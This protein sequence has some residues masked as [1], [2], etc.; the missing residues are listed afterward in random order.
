MGE[1]HQHHL[2]VYLT[3]ILPQ[4]GLDAETYAPYIT[5]ILPDPEHDNDRPQNLDDDEELEEEL[6]GI[7]QLL[8]AS[9][10][11]HCD[12]TQTWVDLKAAIKCKDAAYR[13]DLRLAR[14]RTNERRK[15]EIESNTRTELE[16]AR[17]SQE[18]RR[19]VE[20]REAQERKEM[21]PA[22]RAILEQYAYVE[23][24]LYDND[25]NLIV[26]PAADADAGKS[27]GGGGDDDGNA[28]SSGGD[29]RGSIGKALIETDTS[30]RAVAQKYKQEATQQARA[31][32]GPT[33]QE[34]RGKTK[35]AKL[36]KMK[37]KEERRKRAQKGE[38]K[39]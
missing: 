11:S 29:K 17:N 34:E 21:D 2:E 31:T 30:N 18:E 32:Q 36:D 26:T 28:T 39:R 35:N 8:Q 4:I 3:S 27:G 33:K 19:V 9:S 25:G 37:Q 14:E 23:S 16:L 7:I 15:E 20:A 12:D 22:K 38:R 13:S 6:E 10:E 5:G 1:N 24:E